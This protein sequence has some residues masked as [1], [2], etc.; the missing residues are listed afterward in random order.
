M[1][2][3]RDGGPVRAEAADQVAG[4]RV[5]RSELTQAD[6]AGLVVRPAA[7]VGGITEPEFGDKLVRKGKI[8]LVAVGR[9]LLK[10]PEWAIKAIETLEKG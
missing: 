4:Q 9:K 7:A 5:P 3:H 10:D 2:S 6:V 1:G 8:D